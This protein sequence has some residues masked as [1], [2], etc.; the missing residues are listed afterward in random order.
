MTFSKVVFFSW[1][2]YITL[3]LNSFILKLDLVSKKNFNTDQD[4]NISLK[5]LWVSWY[6]AEKLNM[7]WNLVNLKNTWLNCD[8]WA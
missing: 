1:L 8:L 5:G 6:K 2:A 7:V 4:K 3:H